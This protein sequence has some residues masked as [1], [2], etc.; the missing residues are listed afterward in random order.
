MVGQCTK[1]T[2]TK[3]R[4]IAIENDLLADEQ[5]HIDKRQ[6]STCTLS[7]SLMLNKSNISSEG[8]VLLNN[9]AKVSLVLN[10][11]MK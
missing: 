2:F 5:M 7:M 9:N 8:I 6:D 11:Y 3:K 4:C 1:I 10:A